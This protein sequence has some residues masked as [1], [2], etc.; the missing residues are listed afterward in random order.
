M[1]VGQSV[2]RPDAPD[3]VKGS[4]QYIEDL[5][6]QGTLLAGV[7]R[8]P[9]AHARILRVDVARA[10]NVPGVHAVLTARD[11]PGR[12]LIPMVQPD[13]PVLAESFVRHVG[14][15]V[16][17]VAGETREAVAEALLAVDVEYEP[18]EAL[19]DMEQALAAGEVMAHWKIRRGEAAV[20]LSRTD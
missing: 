5:A 4:A 12:N 13:W 8:S 10:R 18:I 20:A 3:K 7:L 1:T 17:I 14:E 16:V 15:A 11:I 9:H 19:L 2:R 6:F